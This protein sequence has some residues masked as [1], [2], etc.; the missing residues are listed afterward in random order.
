MIRDPGTPNVVECNYNGCVEYTI[1][2]NTQRLH[3]QLHQFPFNHPFEGLC[4]TNTYSTTWERGTR[5]MWK[6]MAADRLIQGCTYDNNNR[7]RWPE[8][9]QGKKQMLA[10]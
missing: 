9:D 8:K 7:R 6:A 1:D 3:L 10:H 4:G 5:N 2:S